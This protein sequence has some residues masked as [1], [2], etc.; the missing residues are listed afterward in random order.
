MEA[1]LCQASRLLQSVYILLRKTKT[2]G[3]FM[4]FALTTSM[5]KITCGIALVVVGCKHKALQTWFDMEHNLPAK[6]KQSDM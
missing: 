6:Q 3:L 5:M 1:I 4:I 2:C